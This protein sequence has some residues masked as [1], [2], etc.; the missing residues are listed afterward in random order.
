MNL[1]LKNTI[2]WIE[3]LINS[4]VR[5]RFFVLCVYA[6]TGVVS[7]G[8]LIFRSNFVSAPDA[9][10]HVFNVQQYTQEFQSGV[11]YP[12]WLGD[13]YGGYG[14]PIGVVYSPLLYFVAGLI[15]MLGLS[16]SFSLKVTV[17]ASAVVSGYYLCKLLIVFYRPSAALLAG[18][19]YQFAPYRIFDLYGRGA[20]PEYVAFMWL[21]LLVYM[22]YLYVITRKVH[23]LVWIAFGVAGLVLTHFQVAVMFLPTWILLLGYFWFESKGKSFREAMGLASSFL[24]GGCISAIYWLPAFVENKYINT[25][26]LQNLNAGELPVNQEWGNYLNNF[27]F[28]AQVYRGTVWDAIYKANLQI[29]FGAV[30]SFVIILWAVSITIYK[31]RLPAFSWLPMPIAFI[32]LLGVFMSFGVSRPV[33]N[34][35]PGFEVIMFPWRWQTVTSFASVFLLG[36]VVDRGIA[37]FVD[38]NDT[39]D[40]FGRT[41]I[42]SLILTAGYCS[43]GMLMMVINRGNLSDDLMRQFDGTRPLDVSSY[44]WVFDDLYVPAQSVG[45]DYASQ[46]VVERVVSSNVHGSTISVVDETSNKFRFDIQNSGDS[47]INIRT[48]WFPGWKAFVNEQ[49]VDVGVNSKDGTMLVH[50]PDGSSTVVVIFS[51]TPVRK[52]AVW[53]S[54]A[55]LILI[56]C[57]LVMVIV[58]GRLLRSRTGD[59]NEL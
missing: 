19:A 39:I 28:G 23:L 29:G 53:I 4:N 35:L 40:P 56:G 32:G 9:A 14:A 38:A 52:F 57:L 42:V 41:L 45:F 13:W 58:N 46:P 11:L 31:R 30:F 2:L 25:E 55:G 3:K 59:F 21:P 48:F 5:K 54:F 33:W 27:L 26:W 7:L 22:G 16:V 24:I 8:L 10:M 37:L 36:Y 1:R 6:V 12:R 43:L 47:V 50:V 44:E 15:N 49:E 17:L 18:I 51:D 34:Q 20:L